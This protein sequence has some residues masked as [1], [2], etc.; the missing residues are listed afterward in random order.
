VAKGLSVNVGGI[1]T[2][3]ERAMRTGA[4]KILRR[5]GDD[6]AG[7]L[8]RLAPT[9]KVNY[10]VRDAHG[11]A[12]E[13]YSTHPGA[14]AMSAGAFIQPKR[15]K[16]LKFQKN[17][18]TVYTRKPVRVKGTR[19]IPRAL[20]KRRRIVTGAVSRELGDRGGR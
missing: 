4:R 19:Y 10:R 3:H 13:V 17:G 11:D 20:A 8:N 12:V 14:K 5:V 6:M 9:R 16:A 15:G 18:E 2:D 7:E 1:G